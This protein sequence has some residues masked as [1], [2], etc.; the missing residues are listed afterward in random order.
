MK[1]VFALVII[2]CGW[3]G[4]TQTASPFAPVNSAY[5]EQNPVISPDG[6]ALYFTV[7]NHPQNSAGK[8]DL[9]DIWVSLNIAGKW[10]KPIHGGSDIN[11]GNYN[12]VAAFSPDG[13]TLFLLSHYNQSGNVATQGLSYSMKTSSGWSAP[14]NISIP[15]FLNRSSSLSGDVSLDGS[16]FVFS[17]ESYGTLGA[18]DIY[19]SI[20]V[21]DKWR[22][23]INLGGTI[24]STFQEMSPTLSED[25]KT[26]YFA[27]NGKKGFGSFDLFSSNRLDDTWKNWSVPTNLGDTINSD[28]RELYYRIT[29]G[30]KLFTTTR[31]SDGYGDIQQA[32]KIPLPQIDTLI[33]IV[34]NK[35]EQTNSNFILISGSVTSTKT[36]V[37][38]GAKLRFKSDTVFTV[39]SSTN[40]NYG[41]KLPTTKLYTIEVE[42]PGFVNVLEKLDLQTLKLGTLVM[43]FKLQ[44]IEVGT[45]VNLKSVL[46]SMGT[47]TL[48]EESYP[49]L[50]AVIEFLKSNPKVEIELA[51]HTDNRGDAKRNLELSQ[52]RAQ[53][54]KAYLTS[55]GISGKRVKGRGFG[56][57]KPIALNDSEEARRMNR[58]VE[59]SIIK[60]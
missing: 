31:D 54:I 6:K 58:R 30:Q 22:E 34:E 20:K 16:I 39:I 13:Q 42:R 1:S 7:A 24:N 18:E 14:K 45:L 33:K 23:P 36:G 26:I 60:N 11:D 37:G 57:S 29:A 53:T 50:D 55:K 2:F 5:D 21:D 51:G 3:S 15:Y 19:V 32:K 10:Q 9:G 56:G 47:T 27:S 59:F 8:K 43:N 17:A 49:E 28:G 48:L 52:Q 41:I 46:F 25:T 4:Y 40:G 12:G 44:P 38:L 35:Y